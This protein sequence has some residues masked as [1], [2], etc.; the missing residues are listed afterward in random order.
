M[1]IA[2]HSLQA[3]RE[4]VHKNRENLLYESDKKCV[5]AM[6][7]ESLATCDSADLEEKIVE[8]THQRRRRIEAF[9]QHTRRKHR[10]YLEQACPLNH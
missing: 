7:G 1:S 2:I 9:V 5:C 10:L 3:A 4:T 6:L 8:Y